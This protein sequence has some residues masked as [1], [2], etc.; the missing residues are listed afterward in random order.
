MRF[1][2]LN[3]DIRS[4]C[5][6]LCEVCSPTTE[7]S[8]PRGNAC[9]NFEA[10]IILNLIL[11]SRQYPAYIYI[12]PVYIIHVHVICGFMLEF[13]TQL[14]N[15]SMRVCIHSPLW[16]PYLWW[17]NTGS[18]GVS[19]GIQPTAVRVHS[20]HS[21]ANWLRE[22]GLLVLMC[23]TTSVVKWS[24]LRLTGVSVQNWKFVPPQDPLT[25]QS[26]TQT[27]MYMLWYGYGTAWIHTHHCVEVS[28]LHSY[29]F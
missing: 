23:G 18:N 5:H 26:H 15:S 11:C 25:Y 20:I 21:K 17:W 7:Q 14:I 24:W 29:S 4:W 3:Y 1:I 28:V 9:Y 12:Y 27:C 16:S 6:F 22:D 19:N 13:M 10:I 2:S 8:T